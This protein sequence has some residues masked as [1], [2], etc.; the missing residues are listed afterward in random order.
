MRKSLIFFAAFTALAFATSADKSID[1][2]KSTMTVHVYKSGAFSAFG[3]E[4]EVSA[5]IAEGSFNEETP[6]VTLRVESAKMR[7]VDKEISDTDRTKVQ[8]TM[9]GPQVL[10]SSKFPQIVFKSSSADRL[11]DG[12]WLIHGDLML[13]G[14]SHPVNVHV[15]GQSGHYQGF[16]EIKQKDFG[17]TP[18]SAGGGSVKVKN[19]LRI[20]FD[21]WGK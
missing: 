21:I 5:P 8:E 15:E 6:A 14:Q 20:E 9:L 2:A 13:H 16:A 11:G 19:E 12:K 4:H 3:H 7:V 10:D 17:M 1:A 18:V